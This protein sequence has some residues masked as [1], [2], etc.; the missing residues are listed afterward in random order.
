MEK[1]NHGITEGTEKPAQYPAKELTGKIISKCIEVHKTLGPGWTEI[2]YQRALARELGPNFKFAREVEVDVNYKGI[3]LGKKRVD[4]IIDGII[5]ETK[6]KKEIDPQDCIQ[7]LSYLR[8]TNSRVGLLI[9][10]G[11]RKIEVK[12]FVN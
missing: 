9:N 10:F 4:F 3:K 6:A 8:A 2:F 12:R 11:A 1:Q 5:L 7:T